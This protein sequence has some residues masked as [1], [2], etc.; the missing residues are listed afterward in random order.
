VTHFVNDKA[1]DEPLR[2]KTHWD[3]VLEEMVWL[4]TDFQKERKWKHAIARKAAHKAA[5]RVRQRTNERVRAARDA[6]AQLRRVA[7]L[8]GRHVMR[9]WQQIGKLVDYKQQVQLDKRKQKSMSRHLDFLVGQTEQYSSMLAANLASGLH[10]ADDGIDDGDANNERRSNAD[11]ADDDDD[12]GGGGGGGGVDGDDDDDDDASS[13]HSWSSD[14]SSFEAHP[15]TRELLLPESETTSV[16]TST[17]PALDDA[18]DEYVP[19][20]PTHSDAKRARR[21]GDAHAST[22]ATAAAADDD[23]DVDDKKAV[24]AT[25]GTNA[26]GGASD[27]SEVDDDE[28]T[29]AAAERDVDVERLSADAEQAML[30][31]D[32]TRPLDDLL[33]EL[34]G[35]K[36][37]RDDS[38]DDDG[39]DDGAEG[40]RA[41]SGARAGARDVA[42]EGDAARQRIA[43]VAAEAAQL[44]P[45][46]SGCACVRCA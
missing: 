18:D 43:G 11:G 28:S 37:R 24:S 36:R 20:P 2:N 46:A 45:G 8:M 39:D 21:D 14:I 34:R 40:D 23:D 38:K 17:A 16:G 12:D 30:E 15:A 3:S 27:D 41:A 5:S 32:S 22:T 6:E 35:R 1:P 31:R 42:G 13:E 25:A 7:H 26:A 19:P 9:F 33:A 4:A 29:I 44:Q 10:R